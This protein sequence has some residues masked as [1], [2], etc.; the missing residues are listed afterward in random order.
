[1]FPNHYNTLQ[2]VRTATREEIKK[3]YRSLSLKFHPDKNKSVDAHD[4]FI[5]IN[6]AY[7]ILYDIEARTKYDAEYDRRF[8][9]NDQYKDPEFNFRMEQDENEFTYQDQDLN[10]WSKT[11][12]NQ[13]KEYASMKFDEFSNLVLQFVGETG[14]QL[15]NTILVFLG[16]LF[17]MGGCGNLIVGLSTHG[18]IGNA[19]L[20]IIM[21]Q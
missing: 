15:G 14:F 5:E 17:T 21:F 6:E 7:L 4:K 20:G 10:N 8:P 18:E 19:L 3:S 11:A 16:L 1:M 2:L 12:R 13:G 9:K